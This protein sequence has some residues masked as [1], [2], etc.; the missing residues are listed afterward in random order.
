[1]SYYYIISIYTLDLCCLSSDP[2]LFTLSMRSLILGQNLN[3]NVMDNILLSLSIRIGIDLYM[4][5]TNQTVWEEETNAIYRTCRRQESKNVISVSIVR[6]AYHIT[7]IM[8]LTPQT[9]R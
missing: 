7:P 8:L 1:M 4:V 5:C 6:H 3:F 9:S 2:F